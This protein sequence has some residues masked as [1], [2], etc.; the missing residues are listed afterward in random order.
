M[1]DLL[2]LYHTLFLCFSMKDSRLFLSLRV[3]GI[4]DCF[5]PSAT[6]LDSRTLLTFCFQIASRLS[7]S[8]FI[9]FSMASLIAAGGMMFLS[10]TRLTFDSPWICSF[11]KGSSHSG[12][13]YPQRDVS[14]SSSSISP[15]MLRSVVAE[16]FSMANDRFSTPYA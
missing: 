2:L 5:F 15:M 6:R 13:D 4:A 14:V 9:C 1:P 16:R 10:S 7:R 3:K 11:N 12:I 8:A